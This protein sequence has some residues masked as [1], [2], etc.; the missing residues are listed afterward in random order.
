MGDLGAILLDIL[1][2]V[3][4]L[5]GVGFGFGRRLG[6]DPQP[7]ARTAYFLLAPAFIFEVLAGS[8][9][10]GDVVVRMVAVLLLTTTAVALLGWS[11]GRL[12]DRTPTVTA[13]LVLVAVYGNVGNFGLPIVAFEFGDEALDLAGVAFL[14]VNV[15]AFLIGVTAATWRRSHPARALWTAVST[16][17]V[18]VVPLAVAVNAGNSDLPLFLD[19]AIGLL[20]DA[21]IPVMLLTLGVQLARM[22]RPTIGADVIVGSALRL[23]GAPALAAMATVLVGLDGDP[24]GVTIV[25][26]AMPAAVFTA[27]IAIEHD[28]EPDLV[29]TTVLVSTVVSAITLTAVL[30]LV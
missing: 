28:L 9:L 13:A 10:G 18:A 23:L 4:L 19:R 6:V 14:T 17:A 29:T 2:P 25:Q 27:L 11:T 16:P 5:V 8:E 26:S 22:K 30:A 20:A 15:S 7:M 12:L 3:F 24:A 1:A 21:M